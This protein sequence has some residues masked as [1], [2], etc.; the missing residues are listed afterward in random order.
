MRSLAADLRE[1][2]IELRRVYRQIFPATMVP[3]LVAV[4]LAVFGCGPRASA[5]QARIRLAQGAI[6][7]GESVVVPLSLKA[8]EYLRA[9]VEHD[10][11][12]VELTLW[13]PAEKEL[14]VGG[15]VSREGVEVLSFI[16]QTEGVY[17]LRVSAPGAAPAPGTASAP[18]RYAL[19]IE[20]RRSAGPEDHSRVA[21]QERLAEGLRFRD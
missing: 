11:I 8:A 20:A 17:R 3:L 19:F 2:V 6:R 4:A 14:A 7:P 13:G 21:A 10:G 15:P 16:T 18:G 9:A 1:P 5:P 12:K